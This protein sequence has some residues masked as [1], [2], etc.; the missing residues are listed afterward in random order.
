MAE[1]TEPFTAPMRNT[2]SQWRGELLGLWGMGTPKS[3]NFREDCFRSFPVPAYPSKYEDSLSRC[4]VAI[5]TCG[6]ALKLEPTIR[7]KETSHL[8][9][10][11]TPP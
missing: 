11:S 3:R 2:S 4:L 9:N 8:I 10:Q 5:E 6:L 1:E 7:S